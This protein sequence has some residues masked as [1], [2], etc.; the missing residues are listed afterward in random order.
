MR[1]CRA[2][3]GTGRKLVGKLFFLLSPLCGKAGKTG[4]FSSLSSCAVGKDGL[5]P[6]L[7]FPRLGAA[8]DQVRR[9][10]KK[11]G[12]KTHSSLTSAV[13]DLGVYCL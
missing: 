7:P 4:E 10:I 5:A 2:S 8:K 3:E 6:S 1:V 13:N 11:S 9:L 12:R